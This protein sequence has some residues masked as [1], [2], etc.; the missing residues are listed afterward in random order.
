M[1]R[2]ESHKF[3]AKQVVNCSSDQWL[4]FCLGGGNVSAFRVRRPSVTVKSLFIV[5][6]SRPRFVIADSS[7]CAAA[8]LLGAR[9]WVI[10]RGCRVLPDNAQQANIDAP[11]GLVYWVHWEM[12][13]ERLFMGA[14]W[15]RTWREGS[16]AVD[17][18]G[19]VEK[20][21]DMGISL[22]RGPVWEPGVDSLA[23]TFGRKG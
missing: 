20:A 23:G 18:G 1:F 13:V 19:Y 7:E 9:V 16:P 5:N 2:V 15:R 4:M 10:S 8:G 6:R 11:G 22:H 17:P 14:L 21:L 12:E 3:Y